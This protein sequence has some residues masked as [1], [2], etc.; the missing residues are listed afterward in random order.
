MTL[1][2]DPAFFYLQETHTR[3][4]EQVWNSEQTGCDLVLF[5][6]E[7]KKKKG[8]MNSSHGNAL[9]AIPQLIVKKNLGCVT[10]SPAPLCAAGREVLVEC[11]GTAHALQRL[12][13]V[14]FSLTRMLQ[15]RR[16]GDERKKKKDPTSKRALPTLPLCFGIHTGVLGLTSLCENCLPQH[17]SMVCR[18]SPSSF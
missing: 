16:R 15:K 14:L 3:S 4:I 7:K 8:R 5:W 11:V 13:Y 12:R 17:G 6:K 18:S 1:G 9:F 10:G 2:L